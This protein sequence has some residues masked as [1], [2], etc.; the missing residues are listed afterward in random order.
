MSRIYRSIAPLRLGLAGGGTDV[1]PYCDQ[2]GGLVLN[3]TINHYA[4]CTIIPDGTEY[5]SFEAQDLELSEILPVNFSVVETGGLAL[6]RAVH[7][8]MLEKHPEVTCSG[9]LVS[10]HC[11]A[12]P[13]S[14]LGSSSTVVV[15]MVQAYSEW[16]GLPLGEYDVARY[17]YEIERLRL[18][19]TG[20]RQDHYAAAFGGFN[21]M[22]FHP[23]D[24]VTVN[25]LRV[26]QW[27]VNELEESLLLFY[28]AVNRESRH[29]IDEQALNVV[30]SHH[31]AIEATHR[32]KDGAARMKDALLKGNIEKIGEIL[33]GSWLAK[34]QLADGISTP[35][36]EL[37]FNT[38]MQAGAIAGKVSGA[39]GGGF[40][41][42]LVP[43]EKRRQVERALRDCEGWCMPFRFSNEGAQA[44]SITQ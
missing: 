25:P 35:R 28:S 29:I 15:A 38:A 34:R 8:F 37:I 13:G 5:V 43:P 33:T 36:M 12:P 9:A 17:A 3:A 10:T 19:L 39:G 23:N 14:G 21:F 6:H 42:L 40:I 27:I 11:D 4:H 24:F 41:M 2:Y 1:S 44:W 32:L 30:R 16:L 7:R 18:K 22:E 20:G 31:G 26:K